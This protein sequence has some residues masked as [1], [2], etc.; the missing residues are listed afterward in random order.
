M[1]KSNTPLE[2]DMLMIKIQALEWL[3]RR[4]QG[5]VLNKVTKD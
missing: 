1:Q 2:D 3:Q 4:I 5:L